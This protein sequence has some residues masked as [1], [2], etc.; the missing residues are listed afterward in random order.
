MTL[1]SHNQGDSGE[2]ED[3]KGGG[4][5]VTTLLVRGWAPKTL[6][7]WEVIAGGAGHQQ[8]PELMANKRTMLPKLFISYII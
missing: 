2:T 4:T 3:E 8:L 5:A 6:T 7:P 1:V